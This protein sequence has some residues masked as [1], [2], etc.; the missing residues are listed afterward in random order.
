MGRS[1]VINYCDVAEDTPIQRCAEVVIFAGDVNI[2]INNDDSHLDARF[3]A[4]PLPGDCSTML[5]VKIYRLIQVCTLTIG[6][7]SLVFIV[8]APVPESAP[9]RRRRTQS[10]AARH[11]SGLKAGIGWEKRIEYAEEV[12]ELWSWG[13]TQYMTWAYPAV[14]CTPRPQSSLGM[15]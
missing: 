15:S 1:D 3:N 6:L 5:F 4:G 2:N 14:S 13:F 9:S 12:K 8:T 7:L 10:H 11:R